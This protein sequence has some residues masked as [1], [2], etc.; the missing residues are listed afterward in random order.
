MI[1]V[2]AFLKKLGSLG[3][4]SFQIPLL[5]CLLNFINCLERFRFGISC[6]YVVILW[7]WAHVMYTWFYLFFSWTIRHTLKL[8]R[9]KKEEEEGNTIYFCHCLFW[10]RMPHLQ[11]LYLS[12]LCVP[13]LMKILRYLRGFPRTSLPNYNKNLKIN[14]KSYNLRIIF[15]GISRQIHNKF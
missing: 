3:V 11:S 6:F 4:D 10:G 9:K 7:S 1:K 13:S 15:N 8:E 14:S 12:T 5:V 2:S